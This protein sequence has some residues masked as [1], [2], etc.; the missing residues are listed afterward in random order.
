MK[1]FSTFA[2]E[3]MI[4]LFNNHFHEVGSDLK[5]TDPIKYKDYESTDYITYSLNVISY[6]FKKRGNNKAAYQ[7]WKLGGKGTD[8][9]KYLVN[10]HN[11]KGI[12]INPDSIHPIDASPEHTYS[13][14]LASK[15]CKYYQ[16]PLE[17]KVHNY[18][19]T[20]K[21]HSAFQ[22][23]NETT[24]VTTLNSIDIASLD[25]IKFGFGISKGGKHAWLFSKGKVYEVH[26]DK[27]GSELYEVTSLRI[28]P[29]LSG[30]I[31]VPHDQVIHLAA[32]AKLKC[33]G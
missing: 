30:A 10:T 29:W 15:A 16:V 28:F 33:G 23:L 27:I 9:A 1:T 12:Y 13:S 32:S 7:I 26:W 14:H 3:K 24:P 5:K 22:K 2:Y 11:W 17:Y 21:S 19:I 20:P 18:T 6:A 25:F 4:D 31:V 8:L